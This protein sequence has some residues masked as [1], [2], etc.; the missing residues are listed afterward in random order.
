[1]DKINPDW[2]LLK[3]PQPLFHAFTPTE[4]KLKLIAKE[5]MEKKFNLSD[6]F[7]RY[8][9]IYRI[10]HYYLSGMSFSIFYEI[11]KE[12][13]MQALLGFTEI[14]PNFK[15]SVFFKLFDESLWGRDFARQAKEVFKIVM[16]ELKLKRLSTSSPDE[17]II[18]M[19]KMV[20]FKIDGILKN[21][22]IWNGKFFSDTIL[23]ITE[24]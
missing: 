2:E 3:H 14:Y 19:S 7:R 21:N 22:F 20:G 1:M 17:K 15:A 24:E 18:R 13:K 10:L 8:D 9:A 5:L 11:R 6:E 16:D 4:E 23:S 12:D